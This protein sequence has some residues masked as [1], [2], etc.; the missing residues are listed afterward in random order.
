MIINED[1]KVSYMGD[2]ATTAFPIPYKFIEAADIKLIVY[3]L[4]TETETEITRDFYIDTESSVLYYPG[5]PPGQE[6]GE[7]ERPPILP[8]GKKLTIYRDTPATQ[9][10]DMGDKYPLPVLEKMSDKLTLIAQEIKEELARTLK[11]S[12][13]SDEKSDELLNRIFAAASDAVRA[14]VSA[15]GSKTA[16]EDSVAEAGKIAAEIG[17]HI[18]HV[19]EIERSLDAASKYLGARATVFDVTKSYQAADIVMLMDGSCYRC[20]SSSQGEYPEVSHKWVPVTT[21]TVDTFERDENDDLMPLSY[22]HAS[23]QWGIDGNGDIYP[24]EVL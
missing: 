19:E 10:V 23:R 4:A 18:E 6:L 8:V 24:R 7:A 14:A 1:T 3:E 13:S 9:T 16:A 17:G 5:Y 2:G 12:K 11:V 20:L 15:Y 21:A 22:P